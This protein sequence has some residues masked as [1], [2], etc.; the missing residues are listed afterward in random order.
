MDFPRSAADLDH[1]DKPLMA[2]DADHPGF[3]DPEY[4]QRRD[5]ITDKANRF[6]QLV[7]T[8]IPS[9]DLIQR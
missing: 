3:N 1:Q 8:L 7:A 4:R 6:R 2:L 5:D 9:L